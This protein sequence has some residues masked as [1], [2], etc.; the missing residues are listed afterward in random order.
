MVT[1]NTKL[2]RFTADLDRKRGLRG[3]LGPKRQEITG[4]SR[5][6]R[7][8]EVHDFHGLYRVYIIRIPAVHE[9]GGSRSR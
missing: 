9:M 1:I 7:D 3:T 2:G 8:E 4:D 6:I 5:K